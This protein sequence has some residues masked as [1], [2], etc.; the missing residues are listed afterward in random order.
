MHY[1]YKKIFNSD[2]NI[3][4]IS[5]SLDYFVRELEIS[6]EE[7]KCT[8]R[9]EILAAQLPN[10][11]ENR[12]IQLQELESILKLIEKKRNIEHTA[13]YKKL[14]DQEQR[15]L[16]TTDLERYADNNQ[17]VAAYDLIILEVARVRNMFLGRF[18]ALET[19]NWM[20]GH[21]AKLKVAGMEMAEVNE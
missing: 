20:I 10:Y 6:K 17:D 3:D 19:K 21:I 1:W 12:W 14:M 7:I 9:V 11:V 16:N 4:I 2:C 8:G 15:R 5:E 13:V 18:K